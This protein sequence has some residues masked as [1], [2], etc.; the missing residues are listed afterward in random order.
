MGDKLPAL[1][2]AAMV[3]WT[4][5]AAPAG[6]TVEVR[7]GKFD[8]ANVPVTLALPEALAG[9]AR[10]RLTRLDTKQAVPAQLAPGK[11]PALV[12]MLADP[13]RRGQVRRYRLEALA[14]A[15]SA[16]RV[17]A[18]T[19][20]D[21]G[22]RLSVAVDGKGVLTY[23]HAVV[24]PPEGMDTR[25]R[26]SGHIHPLR[27][28]RGDVLTDDFA[29]DHAH[30]HGVMFPWTKCTFEGRP[31]EFWNQKLGLGTVEHA[32]FEGFGGGEVFGHFAATLRHVAL[33]APGGPKAALRETWRVRVYRRTDGFL[34]DLDSAQACATKAPLE[35]Q[36]YHYGGM[37]IRCRREW[38]GKGDFLTSE[39]RTRKDGNHTRP[40]WVDVHGKI[41]GKPTGAAILCH[42][43]NFRFPQ[44]V[45]LHPDK[46]YFCFAPMVLG[47]FR[48]EPGKPYVS[49]YRFYVH[50]G[51][52]DPAVAEALWNDYAHPA[53]ARIV[54]AP[55][56]ARETRKIVLI[57]GRPSHSKD[58]HA[59]DK[60]A[61][62]LKRCLDTSPDAKGVRTEVHF[63]GWPKDANTLNDAA[64]IVLLSD[65]FGGHPFFSVP[66]RAAHVE[67]LMRRG[68]GLAC[69]HYAVAALPPHEETL[70]AWI[71]GIY[72]QGYSKNP[73]N[74]VEVRPATPSHPICRGWK[75][76]TVK[77][78]LYY[79]I[80][81]GGDGGKATPIMT[82]LLPPKSPKREVVAWA[83][84]RADGGRGF[85]FTGAHF[86]KNWYIPEFRTM[87][88]NAILWV[89][90]VDVPA[91]GVRST[92][93][94]ETAGKPAR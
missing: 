1:L 5:A 32:R 13:L 63:N 12:W 82:A 59:W 78:E 93:G 74:T 86:H 48:I 2:A 4:G 11:P 3:L 49:R 27:N 71:G 50:D 46:P 87:V 88:L 62:L 80:W 15:P 70:R 66:R 17:A 47:A 34:F 72:K 31:A 39:G 28:P 51:R 33:K 68:V 75:P 61:R 20:R 60:D 53:E 10:C 26:R 92:V 77:D 91:G 14:A 55:P 16:G 56:A 30:Q 45:R 58:T 8:R 85:G 52:L 89:A 29:P 21:D 57:A 7:A 65:G 64:A 9:A 84:E 6:V 54:D 24:E 42:P 41:G 44:P 43:S 76:Y 19:V 36:K 94:R 40:R 83:L 69:I 73:M 90:K 79:R 38:I 18:V 25:Y 35:I 37:A 81:F 67:R 22:K 23:N